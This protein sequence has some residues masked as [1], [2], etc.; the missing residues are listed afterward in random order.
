MK[1]NSMLISYSKS[2]PFRSALIELGFYVGKTYIDSID[3]GTVASLNKNFILNPLNDFDLQ[4]FQTR[5]GITYKDPSLS[6]DSSTI[7]LNRKLESQSSSRISH[8]QFLK[9]NS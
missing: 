1:Q 4:L 2:T 3:M 9:F 7:L 6:F 8:T 5:A